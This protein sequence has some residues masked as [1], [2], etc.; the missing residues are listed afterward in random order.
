MR[1]AYTKLMLQKSK[2]LLEQRPELFEQYVV[3]AK[4]LE[5][6]GDKNVVRELF[7][8][9]YDQDLLRPELI[10]EERSP[11]TAQ[12]LFSFEQYD[13]FKAMLLERGEK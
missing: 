13:L 10:L 3:F 12:M 1:N 5:G 8:Y 4:T 7:Q 6:S 11:F 9:F 2:L